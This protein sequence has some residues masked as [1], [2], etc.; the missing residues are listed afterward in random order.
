MGKA[1]CFV[2]STQR[3]SDSEFDGLLESGGLGVLG[4]ELCDL[5]LARETDLFEEPDAPEVG[6][7]F[8]PAE[9]VAGGNGMRVMVVVP[10]FAAG[11]KSDP[12]VIARIVAGFKATAAPHVGC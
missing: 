5:N 10:A 12:P 1:V 7:D 3:E 11:E 9:A 8:V 2:F 6:I 4:V